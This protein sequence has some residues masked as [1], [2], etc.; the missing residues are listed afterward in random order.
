[1]VLISTQGIATGNVT[2]LMGCIHKQTMLDLNTL[3]MYVV[4]FCLKGKAVNVGG[5]TGNIRVNIEN[6]KKHV[7]N[8]M[9]HSGSSIGEY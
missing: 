6:S 3:K 7:C 9:M 2:V 8:H 1:M 5:K 4:L